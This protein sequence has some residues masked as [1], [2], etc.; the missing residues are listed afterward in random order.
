M[1][2][3]PV[4]QMEDLL[5]GLGGESEHTKREFVVESNPAVDTM[6]Q[7]LNTLSE[8]YEYLPFKNSDSRMYNMCKDY[9]P[10]EYSSRDI[11]QF[12]VA[13]LRYESDF[14][15]PRRCFSQC[16]G[17]YISA[18]INQCPEKTV[19]V[20]TK[21]LTFKIHSLG[22]RNEDHIIIVQGDAGDDLGGQMSGGKIVVENNA[23]ECLGYNM[24][25]GEIVVH[26]DIKGKIGGFI[27]YHNSNPGPGTTPQGPRM[28]GGIIRIEGN[29]D[30]LTTN[31]Q[32]G[33]IYHKGKLIV[34]D[35]KRV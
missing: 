2:A 22:I 18:L 26:G 7:G 6:V 17:L 4:L 8:H 5:G 25:G 1:N 31:L 29:Y 9:V 13:L 3:A 16:A 27:Q 11:T 30:K 21:H 34:K 32:G 15:E 20:M 14:R 35:G 33:N 23:E 28:Y 12:C 24:S 10:S 19:T